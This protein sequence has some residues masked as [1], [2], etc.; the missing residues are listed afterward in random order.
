MRGEDSRVAQLKV[1]TGRRAGDRVEILD[2]LADEDLAL[3]HLVERAAL[4]Q[5]GRALRRLARRHDRAMARRRAPGPPGAQ[6]LDENR[7]DLLYLQEG[8]LA[9]A[10]AGSAEPTL[11]TLSTCALLITDPGMPGVPSAPRG[12]PKLKCRVC[13]FTETDTVAA[14]PGSSV[15]T[16]SICAAT[17][18]RMASINSFRPVSWARISAEIRGEPSAG[19]EG[20]KGIFLEVRS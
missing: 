16:L 10:D 18:V 17:M 2:G 19:R 1:S 4:E 14:W 7:P 9:L 3:D 12:M 15:A 20:S 6:L 11:D 13:P 8:G 5:F